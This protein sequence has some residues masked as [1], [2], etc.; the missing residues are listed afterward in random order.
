[1]E[2]VARITRDGGLEFGERNRVIFKRYLAEHPGM[3]LKISPVLPESGKQRRFYHGA[4]I[5]LWA[6]LDGK[7]YRDHQVLADLHELAKLEFNGEVIT[8]GGELKKVGRSTS[9]K[10]R[11]GFLERVIAYLQEQ[12]G[13]DPSVVLNPAEYKRFNDEIFM[14]GKHD[15]Y[16]DYLKETGIL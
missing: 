11:D 1:M 4:I 8:V 6:Y 14:H 2:F 5:P 10:L 12:Y 15:T 3:V 9:G 16:M 13:I 7:D